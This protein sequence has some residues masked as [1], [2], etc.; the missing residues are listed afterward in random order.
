MKNMIKKKIL[1]KTLFDFTLAKIPLYIFSTNIGTAGRQVACV[2][3]IIGMN[4]VDFSEAMREA[5]KKGMG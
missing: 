5:R 3:F 4:T 2:S 1:T